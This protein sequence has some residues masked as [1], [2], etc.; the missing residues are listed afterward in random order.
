MYNPGLLSESRRCSKHVRVSA[1]LRIHLICEDVNGRANVWKSFRFGC[2]LLHVL[3][4]DD[5]ARVSNRRTREG[6]EPEICT[7]RIE[8]KI[9]FC[10]ATPHA[11]DIG[12]VY[13]NLMGIEFIRRNCRIR[14]AKNSNSSVE[15][16]LA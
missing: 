6:N 11:I 13:E 3:I 5:E 9:N 8:W 1:W 16:E 2:C 10:D 14:H 15:L 7:R 4:N 12:V